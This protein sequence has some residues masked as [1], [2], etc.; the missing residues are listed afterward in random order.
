MKL[1]F[2]FNH[3]TLAEVTEHERLAYRGRIMRLT[4]R[5]QERLTALAS[6]RYY[7]PAEPEQ[8]GAA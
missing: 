4:E 7:I 8:E 3:L 2:P 1:R 5:E 6:R